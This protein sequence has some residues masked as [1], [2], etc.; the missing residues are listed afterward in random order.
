MC[1]NSTKNTKIK[2]SECAT[3]KNE[4]TFP[5]EEKTV[6][7]K[8]VA[9]H[10]P[11]LT[12]AGERER[13]REAVS[14]IRHQMPEHKRGLYRPS[15]LVRLNIFRASYRRL[16]EGFFRISTVV[17]FFFFF[18]FF[19][20]YVFQFYTSIGFSAILCLTVFYSCKENRVPCFFVQLYYRNPCFFS[21]E[22]GEYANRARTA[23]SIEKG[24]VAFFWPGICW[25]LRGKISSKQDG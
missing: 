9:K 4:T 25:R 8:A 6:T 17:F 19:P 18:F 2:E 7:I 1:F 23:P 14:S 13:E 16:V 24:S 3:G 20:F 5:T 22:R 21:S 10:S 12:F 15:R 11:K